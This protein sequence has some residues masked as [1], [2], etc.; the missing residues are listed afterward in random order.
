MVN[1]TSSVLLAAGLCA[2]VT[3]Q[4]PPTFDG[5]RSATP[6]AP[7]AD[8]GGLLGGGAP[9]AFD[10]L[11]RNLPVLQEPDYSMR[12][13]FQQAHGDFMLKRERYDP[14]LEV[15]VQYVPNDEVNGEAGHFDLYNGFFD[16]EAAITVSTDAYIELGAYLGMRNYATTNMIGFADERLFS[17]GAKLGFGYFL[18][19]NL[20]LE[21]MIAPGV[22]S[23]LDG[24]LHSDDYDFP[25]SLL[26]T[27]RREDDLFF[28][29]GV[30]YNEVFVDANVLPWLGLSW[31]FLDQWR[32]DVLA[33]ESVELSYWATPEFG[34]LAGG[35][36][37]GAQYFVRS[38]IATGSQRANVNVQE[39]IIYGGLMWRPTDVLS[40]AGRLGAVVA[41][42]YK[43]DDG[44][45]A[46]ARVDGTLDPAMFL[47]FTFGFD[48]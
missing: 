9:A 28:K 15:G 44:N 33:P 22:W 7:A 30:R 27:I 11:R 34:I 29:V 1:S 17:A 4:G 25:T 31:Q 20:L 40:L 12:G 35:E 19:E 10:P 18:D 32:L 47:E 23:D 45:A 16:L 26:L 46:T 41:G 37:Q 43:L 2:A 14:M 24:T 39:I 42:D 8:E 36:I 6:P 48:F 13:L 38:D 5:F 3:A 21:G